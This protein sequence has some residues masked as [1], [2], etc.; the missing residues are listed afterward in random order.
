MAD[1]G[2]SP[3]VASNRVMAVDALRGFDMFWI[4][5]GQEL[6][7]AVAKMFADPLP[8]TVARQ[9]EHVEWE[10]FVAW[11]LIM[12]L[13]LFVVGVAMPFSFGRRI[14]KGESK[15]DMLRKVIRRTLVLFVLGMAVQG[16][17]L[18][19]KL[20]TLHIYCNTLQAIAAGYFV[21][22]LL[23]LYTG[24]V[25][26]VLFAAAMLVGFWA[27]VMFVPVPGYGTG[28]LRPD[29]NLALAVD[30]LILGR[31][32]DGTS[33]TWI[34]SSMTFTASVLLGVFGGEVLRSNRS[35][36]SKFAVLTGLGFAS[37]AAGWIWAEY[38]GF[39]IIK[40][41]WTSS[42]TL[43]AA[44]WSYLL[45]ALFYLLIDIWGL[46]RWAFPFVVIGMNAITIYVAVH[47]I[48]FRTISEGLV[49]GLASHLGRAGPPT[50]EF[51]AVALGWLALYH[52]YRQKIFLRI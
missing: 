11:D 36:G 2:N 42:M 8:P 13:F 34:L 22:S 43:W 21:S 40:H 37:L 25:F 47:F 16:N 44:G 38:L 10:G 17:L 49:G 9:F 1:A 19:F 52:M 12:P 46:R 3:V 4:V 27:L 23:L 51:G 32:R 31:F 45:L 33:Y 50:I 6:A 7:L 18:Q 29:A 48:P 14:E 24:I 20:S 39:P 35:Q 41:I 30:E 28:T 5:G 15:Q 26:Q